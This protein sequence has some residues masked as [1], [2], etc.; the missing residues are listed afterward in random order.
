MVDRA[1]EPMHVAMAPW[2]DIDCQGTDRFE[3][4]LFPAIDRAV[5]P[6]VELGT[7]PIR[8]GLAI[9]L[10][11]ERPGLPIELATAL[12]FSAA[13]RYSSQCSAIAMIEAGH[14]AGMLALHTTLSKMAEGVFDACVIAGVESYLTPETLEWLEAND[15]LH[16]AGRLNNAWGF[17]PGEGAGAALVVTERALESLEL[18][19]LGRVVSVGRGVEPNRIKTQTVCV[20]EGLTTAFRECLAGLPNGATVTDVYGDLNGEPYRADEFGFAALRTRESFTSTSEF[21]APADCWG[22]VSAASCPL[23]MMLSVAASAK[24]YSRGPFSLIWA[25]SEAGE[26]GTALLELPVVERE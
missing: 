6:L 23:G 2:L 21:V 7:P 3:A 11:T 1:G 24:G 15:Q 12:R 17:V 20:G 26:R 25:S 13:D 4:L 5:A 18:E 16:G 19:P 8:M 22:D 14:A 9:G 10:P